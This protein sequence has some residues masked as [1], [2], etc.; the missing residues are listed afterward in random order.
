VFGKVSVGRSPDGKKKVSIPFRGS[1]FGKAKYEQQYGK[2]EDV[3]IPFRGSVFG[4]SSLRRPY[5]DW[6]S[7]AKSTPPIKLGYILP[8]VL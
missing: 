7:A 3:S 4:K 2:K 6:V 1:V 5:G 8:K